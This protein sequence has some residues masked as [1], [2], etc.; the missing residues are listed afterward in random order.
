MPTFLSCSIAVKPSLGKSDEIS[1]V[2]RKLF[3]DE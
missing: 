1:G 3:P 2:W